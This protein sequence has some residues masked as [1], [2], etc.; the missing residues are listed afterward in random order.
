MEWWSTCWAWRLSIV[1]QLAHLVGEAD[2]PSLRPDTNT[3][4][5]AWAIHQAQTTVDFARRSR[6]AAWLLGGLNFQIEHHLLPRICHINYPAISPLVEST[7][8]EFGVKYSA[9]PSFRAGVVSHFRWLRRM[10]RQVSP[11]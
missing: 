7:C 11:T 10:A 8:K 3:I 6:T 1:F 5:N 9:H 4:E 2:F